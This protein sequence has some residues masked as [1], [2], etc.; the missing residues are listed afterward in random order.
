MSVGR[1]CRREVQ[2][3]APGESVRAVSQRMRGHNVGTIIVKDEQ[4]RPAGIVTDRDLVTR[5]IAD[6]K[7]PKVT[8]VL[9]VMT[10]VLRS[11]T[12]DTSIESALGMMRSSQCR[13]LPVVGRDGE[14]VGVISLDDVLE[15][16]SEE[17][18]TIGGL[19]RAEAPAR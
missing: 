16:L 11:V 12:E 7:D 10:S 15:L 8:P 4:G 13:R 18:Q 5:V 1:I 19:L 14:L 9:E 2:V 17:F 3:A 6:G